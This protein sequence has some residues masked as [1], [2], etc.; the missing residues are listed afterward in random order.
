M[1]PLLCRAALPTTS[2]GA[3]ARD[4]KRV[5]GAAAAVTRWSRR[6]LIVV[7]VLGANF[8][9]P[10]ALPGDPL[11]A[12][13][14]PS[15]AHYLADPELLAKV[16]AMYGLDQPLTGQMLDYARSLATGDL[17]WSIRYN[18]PVNAKI[19]ERFGWTVLIVMPALVIASAISILGGLAAG[20]RRGS[21]SDRLW[22]GFFGWGSS[23][24]RSRS[25]DTSSRSGSSSCSPSPCDGPPSEGP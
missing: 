22:V 14:D 15:T 25:P 19:G 4:S 5:H 10:R 2:A 18:Q 8:A 11:L 17:G 23:R 9:L 3:P 1:P 12:L 20:W 6:V 13:S 16:Q 21:R 7:I 24:W